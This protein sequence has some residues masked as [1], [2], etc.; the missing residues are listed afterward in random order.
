MK[1]LYRTDGRRFHIVFDIW[2]KKYIVQYHRTMT[3][4]CAATFT[5]IVTCEQRKSARNDKKSAWTG[6][7]E[8]YKIT[9]EIRK[10]KKKH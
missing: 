4:V 1:S 2:T 8:K 5:R 7:K 9:K 6:A 10:E 3:K